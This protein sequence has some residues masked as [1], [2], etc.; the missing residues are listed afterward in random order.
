M[1][2][3][4]LGKFQTDNLEST[5]GIYRQMCGANYNAPVRQV[6]E[7]ERMLK[8]VEFL[9]IKSTS[10]DLKISLF[11][12]SGKVLDVYDSIFRFHKHCWRRQRD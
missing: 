12:C 5:F 1:S 7:A 2:Y 4:L 10:I 9:K 3:F 11:N 8:V 6:L